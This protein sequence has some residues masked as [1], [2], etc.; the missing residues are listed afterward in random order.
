MQKKT[1]MVSRI[2]LSQRNQNGKA[3]NSGRSVEHAWGVREGYN[4]SRSG[5]SIWTLHMGCWCATR[6]VFDTPA[7]DVW[8]KSYI[9]DVW[10]ITQPSPLVMW[11][12]FS[13]LARFDITA[14]N[15]YI[16]G[17]H[18]HIL[19]INNDH[20]KVWALFVFG[21]RICR[22]TKGVIQLHTFRVLI[23]YARNAVN[24]SR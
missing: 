7:T 10:H 12:C 19:L 22:A 2:C 16:Y 13:W 24:A 8:S 23:N 17:R 15:I 14:E 4:R 18:R 9:C 11:R 3:L 6:F 20:I 1:Y 21:M 5:L